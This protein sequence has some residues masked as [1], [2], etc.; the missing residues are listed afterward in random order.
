[1]GVYGW[2]LASLIGAALLGGYLL[3]TAASIFLSNLLPVPRSEATML[4]HL[5]GFAFY[6]SAIVWVFHLRQPGRAWL[7]LIVAS[8]LLYAASY[9]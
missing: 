3:A 8:A 4:G 1:M 7:S 5:L 6:T 9:L 2:R